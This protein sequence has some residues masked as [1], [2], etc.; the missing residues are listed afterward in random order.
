MSIPDSQW[1]LV[2]MHVG[3]IVVSSVLLA[4]GPRYITS[5]EVGLLVLLESVLAPIL[6]WIVVGEDPGSYALVGGA[7]VVGALAVSNLV[8][9]RRRRPRA[10]RQGPS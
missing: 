6:A 3:F 7:V 9:L 10:A 1:V 4:I 8:A 5:A 2:A